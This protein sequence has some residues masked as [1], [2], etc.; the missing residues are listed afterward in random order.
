MLLTN[1][2]LSDIENLLVRHSIGLPAQ[3]DKMFDDSFYS[4]TKTTFP[5]HNILKVDEEK[6]VIEMAVSGYTKDD[7]TIEVKEGVLTVSGEKS[8]TNGD[9]NSESKYVYRGI[10]SRT[11]RKSFTL[12]DDMRVQGADVKDGLL[13]I[14]LEREVPEHRKS[15][16]IE[17]GR[18]TEG[19]TKILETAKKMIS[20]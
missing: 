7:I 16:K 11:F 12:S 15:K 9:S 10:A 4:S 19:F 2:P 8:K 13:L 20:S 1:F 6:Y 14:A 18:Q 17:I 3:L 5:P